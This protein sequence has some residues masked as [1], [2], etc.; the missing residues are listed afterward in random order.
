ME[1]GKLEIKL[2]NKCGRKNR[3]KVF[4]TSGSGGPLRRRFTL[5]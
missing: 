1:R 5:K 4:G 3:K 2:K